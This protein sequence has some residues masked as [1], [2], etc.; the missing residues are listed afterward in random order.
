[1]TVARGVP[2]DTW[3]TQERVE[4]LAK[5]YCRGFIRHCGLEAVHIKRG[6][7]ESRVL[8]GEHHRTQDNFVHAGLMAT[9]ADHTAGYAAFTT[10]SEEYRIL[11]IEFKINFLR[12][13]YGNALRCR[14]R[15]ISKGKQVIVAES[16][17]YDVRRARE[18]QVAEAL[19]TLIAVPAEKI[20]DV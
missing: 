17:V 8:I 9:M 10:V 12:P 4:F 2:V 13:A 6:L 18:T 1:V 16:K 11:T 19:I 5:D 14:S 3:L 7:F 20:G 15:V